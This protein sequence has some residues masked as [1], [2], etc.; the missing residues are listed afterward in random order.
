MYGME[1]RERPPARGAISGILRGFGADRDRKDFIASRESMIG[2][3][4][5]R[6]SEIGT[7]RAQWLSRYFQR[8]PKGFIAHANQ[9]GGIPAL[10]EM[11]KKEAAYSSL[12]QN[13]EIQGGEQQGIRDVVAPV[14]RDPERTERYAGS[15]EANRRAERTEWAMDPLGRPRDI[16]DP[17]GRL[18]WPNV[19]GRDPTGSETP[20]M[21]AENEEIL[22]HREFI[23][24]T[25]RTHNYSRSDMR[26]ILGR[27]NDMWGN[28]DQKGLEEKAVAGRMV[29]ALNRMKAVD[30]PNYEAFFDAVIGQE[31]LPI[32]IVSGTNDDNHPGD[33][34]PEMLIDGAVYDTMSWFGDALPEGRWNAEKQRFE[35]R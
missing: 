25:M 29:K 21:R 22:K 18:A 5:K 31:G 11:L 4:S 3:G 15:V 1:E 23:S 34:N 19:P 8:D 26:R 33:P 17:E 12:Q 6:I 7:D 13:Q 32:P 14:F 27:V 16:H 10:E 20:S 30:D 9:F 35:K 24:D 28:L 2:A